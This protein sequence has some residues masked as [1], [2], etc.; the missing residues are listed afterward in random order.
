M[1]GESAG[2]G[3][4]ESEASEKLHV[5]DAAGDRVL[6]SASNHSQRPQAAGRLYNHLVI[7][8]LGH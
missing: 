2:E 5:P 8:V 6:S 3:T 4:A 7:V 1:A